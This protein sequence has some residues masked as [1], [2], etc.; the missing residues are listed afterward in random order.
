M[1]ATTSAFDVVPLGVV[2]TVVS[3]QAGAPAGTRFWKKDLPPAPP[4][5]RCSMAGRPVA[6]V[7]RAVG[8]V[9][10]VGDQVELGGPQLRKVDLV[11]ARD[12]DGPTGDLDDPDV[13]GGHGP[14]ISV[15]VR[16]RPVHCGASRLLVG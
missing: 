6:V 7:A 1:S 3:S 13:L 2:T 12:V 14:T 4:G 5:N 16:G 9:Q 15:R 10:V 11:R 8:H